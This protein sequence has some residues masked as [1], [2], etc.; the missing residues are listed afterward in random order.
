VIQAIA[1]LLLCQLAGE[2]LARGLNI[3]MP[4]PVIGL[5]LLLAGLA[6]AALRGAASPHTVA[7]TD[8]GRTTGA[9]L[10]NLSILFVPAGVGVIDHL[11][12][13]SRY[14]VA[15]AVSLVVSTVLTL[16][17]TALVFVGIKRVLV[18]RDRA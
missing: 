3:P 11:D 4:G 14:G 10:Q 15:L 1:I 2:T 12:L 7:D 16:M 8:L 18:A 17:V 5:V 9:L 13:L 6:I